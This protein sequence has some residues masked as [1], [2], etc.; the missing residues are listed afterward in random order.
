M[1]AL[2]IA[3]AE[4][5]AKRSLAGVTGG[6]CLCARGGEVLDRGGRA[7]LSRLRRA[8]RELVAVGARESLARSVVRVT[9]RV[10]ISTRVSAGRPVGFLIVTDAARRDLAAGV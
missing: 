2:A 8:R 6:A 4:I 10:A 3:E 5:S 7:H 9:K 1:T